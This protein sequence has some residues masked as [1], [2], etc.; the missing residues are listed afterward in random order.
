MEPIISP[1]VFYLMGLSTPIKI[2]SACFASC[3]AVLWLSFFIKSKLELC[4]YGVDDDD[5]K[6][7]NSIAKRCVIPMIL[8]ILLSIVT[9][10]ESTI[11]KMLIAQNVTYERVEMVGDT[12]KDVYEDIIAL[13]DGNEANEADGEE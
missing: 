10:S 5:Y 1:W 3:L 13:V 12:V 9:P 11:T 2:S 4:E 6:I 7:S 8:C